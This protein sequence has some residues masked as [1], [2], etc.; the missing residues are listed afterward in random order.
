VDPAAAA[1]NDLAALYLLKQNPMSEYALLKATCPAG[2]KPGQ[3]FIAQAPNG[4]QVVATI[5][6]KYPD[7]V[8]P[9][10]PLWIRYVPVAAPMPIVMSNEDNA[11]PP[12][13]DD[14]AAAEVVTGKKSS[15]LEGAPLQEDLMPCGACCCS[16][17]SCYLKFPDCIGCYNKGTFTCIE[18]ETLWCKTGMNENSSGDSLCLCLS[19]ECEV[20]K[21]GTCCKL[22]ETVCCCNAA[23][24]MPCDEEVPCMIGLFGITC[25]KNYACVFEACKK[26]EVTETRGS[27][28]NQ[29]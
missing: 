17:L 21:P 12:A 7:P 10:T 3:Q 9:N 15:S 23:I 18:L 24:A 16:V 26:M 20:I 1:E 2:M 5:P 29:A 22:Q 28:N 27:V 6:Y 25:V 4:Q 8:P 11:G 13:S 19:G 14:G